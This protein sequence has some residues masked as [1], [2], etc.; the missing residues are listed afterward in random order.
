MFHKRTDCASVGKDSRLCLK[1]QRSVMYIINKDRLKYTKI[2]IDGCD[3]L[4]GIKC[5]YG[6]YLH[7]TDQRLLVELKG[8]D[9]KHAVDQIQA[10][11]K[12]YG[13][14]EG[15]ICFIISSNIP[16]SSTESQLLKA[17]F[18]NDNRGMSLRIERSG[19]EFRY[20]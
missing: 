2:Q 19:Y 18:R 7:N 13:L 14:A 10:T 17:K 9:I 6:V 8:S 11:L 1:E 4:D 3:K 5:D 12:Y 20:S 16:L 15:V